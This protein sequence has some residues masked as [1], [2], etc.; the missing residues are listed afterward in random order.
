MADS[1][2]ST[3][4]FYV[5]VSGGSAASYAKEKLGQAK[6]LVARDG[7]ANLMVLVAS[8]IGIVACAFA[9]EDAKALEDK[10]DASFSKAAKAATTP[11][12]KA[13]IEKEEKDQ[14]EHKDLFIILLVCFSV[15]AAIS[16]VQ[17]GMKGA[18]Y[19]AKD[20]DEHHEHHA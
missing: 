7:V 11:T 12:A 19:F 5:P 4:D 13:A 10:R 16:G 2:F 3:P 17:L 15:G 9:L 18:R 6:A 14:N 1:V 8:I 20:W